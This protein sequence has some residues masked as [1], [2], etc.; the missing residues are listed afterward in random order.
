MREQLVT[1]APIEQGPV[2]PERVSP[3]PAADPA[4][5]A[6]ARDGDEGAFGRLVE[7]HR[8]ELHAHC[9][10]MLGSVHDAE[11]ALQEALLR[12]WRGLGGF[13][14]RSSLRSWLYTIATNACLTAIER[15][16]DRKLPIDF[17]PSDP[18]EGPGE[19][20]VESTWIQPY[21]DE[22]IGL[23]DGPA[24]PDARYEQ[25][26]S[27]ELAFVAA[28]QHLPATQRAVL[29]LRD[30]LG[31][32][33]RETATTLETSVASAN[34]ALQRARATVESRLPDQSQQQTLRALG[35]EEIRE[36]VESYV[37]A[38]ERQDVEKVVS[39]LSEDAAFTMPPLRSWFRGRESI[40]AFL[41][42]SPLSGIWRWKALRVRASGQEA[43]A[44]Y[45][46]SP[47]LEAYERF[48]LNVLTLDG[49]GRVAEVDAFIARVADDPDR[50]VAARMPEQPFDPG[51][52][53]VA[54]ERL[55]LPERL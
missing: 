20:L 55:G 45:S 53:D 27:V 24:G 25:R 43:L 22:A 37:E 1:P 2:Y 16:P 49:E 14:G 29:I 6:A 38:W 42:G 52:V 17:A 3:A 35:D 19:P 39:M 41:A 33:A 28:L 10:R 18:A 34:S 32:S 9:Y 40:R 23:T 46:W 50:E 4:L 48:A 36:L 12:A 44:F 11:D 47:E 8:G 51:R 15:R 5:L 31:Y 7:P 54:F 21:P 13:E 26:E 30:V